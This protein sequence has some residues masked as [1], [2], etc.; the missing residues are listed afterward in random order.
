MLRQFNETLPSGASISHL[1]IKT[2]EDHDWFAQGNV[3]QQTQNLDSFGGYL[4]AS[5]VVH[6]ADPE[7]AQVSIVTRNR[8]SEIKIIKG[9]VCFTKEPSMA[10]NV[11]ELEEYG[12]L[13][14]D[15]QHNIIPR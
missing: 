1:N 14:L 12:Q 10:K 2:P 7:D 4:N 6:S 9:E 13:S 5:V 8:N 11:I 3:L 15:Q